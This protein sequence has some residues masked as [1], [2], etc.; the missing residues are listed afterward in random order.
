MI[1]L[2]TFTTPL[3]AVRTKQ[4]EDYRKSFTK[5]T[6][7]SKRVLVIIFQKYFF[8]KFENNTF[9]FSVALVFEMNLDNYLNYF[10]QFNYFDCYKYQLHIVLGI[11]DSKNS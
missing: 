8:I 11:V 6:K 2:S 10:F 9:L 4:Y 5:N 7:N 1:L 3:I